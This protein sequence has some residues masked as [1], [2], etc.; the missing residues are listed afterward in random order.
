VFRGAFRLALFLR[1]AGN[2]PGVTDP[3]ESTAESAA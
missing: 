2:Q 1:A 3:L